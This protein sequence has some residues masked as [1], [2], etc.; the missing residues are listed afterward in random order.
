MGGGDNL[1][2]DGSPTRL[3]LEHTIKKKLSLTVLLLST[4]SAWTQNEVS[5]YARRPVTLPIETSIA[6]PFTITILVIDP[7]PI[8]FI[9]DCCSG[10]SRGDPGPGLHLSTLRFWLSSQSSPRHCSSF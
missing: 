7:M 10:S 1:L 5:R 8:R 4:T 9:P 3:P 6:I 2:F